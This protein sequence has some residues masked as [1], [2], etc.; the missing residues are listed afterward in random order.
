MEISDIKLKVKKIIIKYV[1][2]IFNLRNIKKQ[3]FNQ[4]HFLKGFLNSL[5]QKL[6]SLFIGHFQLLF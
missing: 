2:T 4:K 6:L 5:I 3:F 1:K